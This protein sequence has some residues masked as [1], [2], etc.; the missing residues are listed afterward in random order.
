MIFCILYGLTKLHK[1]L[2][3]KSRHEKCPNKE[4]FIRIRKNSLFGDFSSSECQFL[5][6]I[7]TAVNTKFLIL[8]LALLE[9]SS[10]TI[11][12]SH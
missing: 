10:Y 2:V 12:Y 1:P 9:P 5:R 4:F 3:D 8:L 6:P 7:L 11:K